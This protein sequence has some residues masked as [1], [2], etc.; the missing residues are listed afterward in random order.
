LAQAQRSAYNFNKARMLLQNDF[1][2][3]GLL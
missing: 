1:P 2:P 3:V